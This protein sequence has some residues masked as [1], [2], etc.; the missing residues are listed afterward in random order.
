MM[1][2]EQWVKDRISLL[3]AGL[4]SEMNEWIKEK[5]RLEINTLKQVL[6]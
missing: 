3:E 4:N 1:K 5:V 6:E 2:T